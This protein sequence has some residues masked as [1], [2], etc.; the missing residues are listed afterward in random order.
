MR[1]GYKYSVAIQAEIMASISHIFSVNGSE[2]HRKV[3][4]CM[5]LI[6]YRARAFD[7][8]GRLYRRNQNKEGGQS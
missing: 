6:S 4:H 3:D 2:K 5:K 8:N 7:G 1:H